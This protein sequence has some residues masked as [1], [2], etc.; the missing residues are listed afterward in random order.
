MVTMKFLICFC[1]AFLSSA[2][3]AEEDKVSTP[4]EVVLKVLD[5]ET[6]KTT[7]FTTPLLKPVSYKKLIIRPRACHKKKI[8]LAHEVKWA[9]LEIWI[10]SSKKSQTT[11]E[12]TKPIIHL[13]FSSW[14]NSEL[15]EFSNT[16]YGVF[17][18]DC[19]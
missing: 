10:Q 9:F 19:R 18:E 11:E 14:L 5:K 16:N 2:L 3:M 7:T 8:G 6:G 17:V 13:V 15:S 4:Q 1:I 12:S